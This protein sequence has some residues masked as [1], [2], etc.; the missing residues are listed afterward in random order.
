M[1]TKSKLVARQA[2]AQ[3]KAFSREGI[4]DLIKNTML[5]KYIFLISKQ[6]FKSAFDIKI[7]KYIKDENNI[8]LTSNV[9]I[10]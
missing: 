6:R 1:Q 10:L 9:D 5:D 3:A 4:Y 2:V 8:L 7:N